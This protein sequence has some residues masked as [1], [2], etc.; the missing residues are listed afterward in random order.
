MP[1]CDM[2]SQHVEHSRYVTDVNKDVYTQ[3]T[4]VYIG[5]DDAT[6]PLLSRAIQYSVFLIYIANND[7]SNSSKRSSKIYGL[8]PDPQSFHDVYTKRLKGLATLLM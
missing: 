6:I 5:M 8:G 2:H 3:T 4:L 7:W 1:D